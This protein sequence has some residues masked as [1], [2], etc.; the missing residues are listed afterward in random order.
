MGL[1]I[2]LDTE[3]ERDWLHRFIL[4]SLAPLQKLFTIRRSR[5]VITYQPS[6][7]VS[8]YLQAREELKARNLPSENSNLYATGDGTKRNYTINCDYG[9]PQKLK[10]K[11]HAQFSTF[12]IGAVTTKGMALI[13][14]I[15]FDLG[16]FSITGRYALFDTQ[17]HDNRQYVYERDVWLAYSLPAYSG[18]GVRNYL[19]TEYSVNKHL[20]L[21][22]RFAHIRYTDI[23]EI[24]SGADTIEGNSKNDI[25][26]QAR[27]K[28]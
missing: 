19:L 4:V 27:I 18:V 21:W 2:Q 1:E 9:L 5:M 7:T 6:K 24:G 17:D 10:F 14:D 23:N 8:L 12:E 28:F 26:I 3:I 11:T 22:I 20:T 13:Q 16:K 25:R 15:S